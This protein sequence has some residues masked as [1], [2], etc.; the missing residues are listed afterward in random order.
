[1]RNVKKCEMEK[2]ELR[3]EKLYGI[4]C[5]RRQ[6][7][8]FEKKKK[9][10]FVSDVVIKCNY[11][12]HYIFFNLQ[13]LILLDLTFILVQ[14]YDHFRRIQNN[15]HFFLKIYKTP[16]SFLVVSRWA[17]VV[18]L[19]LVVS[20]SSVYQRYFGYNPSSAFYHNGA[21]L[22]NNYMSLIT[23]KPVFG[24]GDQVR[25]KPACSATDTSY[26]LELSAI[27]SRDFI[28]SRQRTTKALIRLCGCAGWSAPLLF[29]Y[30]IKMFFHYMAHIM[31]S[32]L[33]NWLSWRTAMQTAKASDQTG[34]MHRLIWVFAGRTCNFAGFVVR[35][36]MLC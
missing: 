35:R 19:Q 33:I 16:Y 9:P 15:M 17:S 26:R 14:N 23:R 7:P 22:I 21:Y 32:V 13:T 30:G 31:F 29:A 6:C 28:L 24:V 20:L 10:G 12:E 4:N 25:L 3:C 1:M 27:A 5:R 8:D 2:C 36:L 18:Q 11:S 34:R